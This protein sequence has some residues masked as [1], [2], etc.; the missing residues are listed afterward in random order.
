MAGA[1]GKQG[2]PEPAA[3][4]VLEYVARAAPHMI[5]AA[6]QEHDRLTDG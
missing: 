5:N 4:E 6:A 1:V 3:R 2:W